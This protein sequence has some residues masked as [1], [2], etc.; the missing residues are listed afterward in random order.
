MVN[1]GQPGWGAQ[2]PPGYPPAPQGTPADQQVKAPAIAM[3][4]V[5][6]IAACFALLGLFLNVVGAGFAAGGSSSMPSFMASRV[7]SI[8]FHLVWLGLDGLIIY[9]ALQ[10][11]KLKSHGLALGA[12]VICVIPFLSPCCVLGIPFGIWALV[13]LAKPE[14][15]QA[16]R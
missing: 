1:Q 10:M 12:A 7:V 4:A 2:P 8:L 13:V 14:V 3:I 16:F 11:M 9:G 15:K 6:G 5:A